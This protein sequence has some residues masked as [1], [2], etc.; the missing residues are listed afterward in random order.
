MQSVINKSIGSD[1]PFPKL[2][3]CRTIIVLFLAPKCGICVHPSE[4]SNYI[5]E[6]DWAM[7]SF[8]DFDGE[9]TLSN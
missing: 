2:M 8:T 9:V 6:N 4:N 5:L 7:D 3:V 1:K